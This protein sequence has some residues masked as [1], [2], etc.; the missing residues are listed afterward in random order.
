MKEI[1]P[2][3]FEPASIVSFPDGNVHSPNYSH[4]RSSFLG[5][6]ENVVFHQD[7]PS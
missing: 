3:T 5:G 7:Y 6:H 2:L 1:N 4:R